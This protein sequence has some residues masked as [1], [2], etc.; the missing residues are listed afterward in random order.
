MKLVLLG[1]MRNIEELVLKCL[2]RE[3]AM[4][5]LLTAEEI[6]AN[7]VKKEAEEK[8]RQEER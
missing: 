8:G 5:E 6:I 7:W 1:Q 4:K 2:T 3:P